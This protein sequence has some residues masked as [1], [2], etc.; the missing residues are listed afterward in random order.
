MCIRETRNYVKSFRMKGLGYFRE[1]Q[2][3][4]EGFGIL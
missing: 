3:A 4:F 1:V 2:S